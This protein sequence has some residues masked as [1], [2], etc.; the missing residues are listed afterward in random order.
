ME[1][2]KTRSYNTSM[3]DIDFSREIDRAKSSEVNKTSPAQLYRITVSTLLN[4]GGIG[5]FVFMLN[6]FATDSEQALYNYK[7]IRTYGFILLAALM[8]IT[9]I[10]FKLVNTTQQIELSKLFPK[11]IVSTIYLTFLYAIC[12]LVWGVISQFIR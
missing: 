9:G 7:T 2:V 6:T 11:L 4:L 5:A 10:T 12:D 1:L 8:V 3:P